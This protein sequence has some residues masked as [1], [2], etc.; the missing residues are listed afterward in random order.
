MDQTLAL[1]AK[2]L[3]DSAS[4][5]GYNATDIFGINGNNISRAW[6]SI[7]SDI[8]YIPER[9]KTD[10]IALSMH[11]V[12]HHLHTEL[13]TSYV[14]AL[15]VH[16]DHSNYVTLPGMWLFNESRNNV[17]LWGLEK[18]GLVG[19][20]IWVHAI[21]LSQ[22]AKAITQWWSALTCPDPTEESRL[23][24]RTREG[25]YSGTGAP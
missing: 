7:T 2:R 5:L 15:L 6:G 9:M 8:F 14:M 13:I 24:W 18:D 12:E 1:A 11:F 23:K 20:Q 22:S 21:K 25:Y 19:D 17:T 10:F 16:G 3:K 4:V